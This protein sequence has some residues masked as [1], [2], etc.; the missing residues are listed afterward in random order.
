[1]R[2]YLSHWK[3]LKIVNGLLYR[4][5]T[6]N[7]ISRELLVIPTSLKQLIL[8]Q[9]HTMSGHQGIERTI[10]LISSR[11]YWP[12]IFNDTTEF[13]KTC[14]RCIIAKEPTPR[15]KA[16][17][18]HLIAN[19]PLDVIAIDFT[20][21]DVAE[22]G[23]ENVLVMT[24]VFS[25]FTLAI[26]TR[27]QIGKTVA[28]RSLLRNGSINWAFQKEYTVIEGKVSRITSFRN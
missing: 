19:K 21:L 10:G 7:G 25:K 24:D 26:P 3:Q 14:S 1:M 6:E 15:I 13:V 12:T 28:K 27:D 2:K 22:S 18:Q 4:I 16:K 5:I 23:I 11:Y 17:M 8:S 20:L 9:M